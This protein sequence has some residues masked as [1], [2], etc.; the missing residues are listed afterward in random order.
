[1][2]ITEQF[3]KMEIKRQAKL[4]TLLLDKDFW[5]TRATEE[6]GLDERYLEKRYFEEETEKWAKN[7]MYAMV[8]Y[9]MEGKTVDSYVNSLNK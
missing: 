2:E 1:M 5:I 4:K 3:M 8:D 6:L 9:I 7:K